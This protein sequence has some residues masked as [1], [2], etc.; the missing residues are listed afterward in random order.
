MTIVLFM[1]SCT[2]TQVFF[3]SF[4]PPFSFF[5]FFGNF[6]GH[7]LQ[8]IKRCNP[9]HTQDRC[10]GVNTLRR[11]QRPCYRS[12]PVQVCTFAHFQQQLKKRNKQNRKKTHFGALQCNAQESPENDDGSLDPVFKSF[13]SSTWCWQNQSIDSARSV[14][15]DAFCSRFLTKPVFL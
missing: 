12:L 9:E 8:N 6:S 10:C 15:L 13:I 4:F 14:K 3:F 11:Q 7:K 5:F 2:V 1:M